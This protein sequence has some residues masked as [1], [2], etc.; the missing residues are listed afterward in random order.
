MKRERMILEI[1]VV[2]VVIVGLFSIG[3]LFTYRP[4]E[5]FNPGE[6]LWIEAADKIW[7]GKGLLEQSTAEL[8]ITSTALQVG[9]FRSSFGEAVNKFLVPIWAF[10]SLM[11]GAAIGYIL[12]RPRP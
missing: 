8:Q 7:E 10:V 2:L 12:R 5:S 3:M 6:R 11:G 4:T 1:L 9:V